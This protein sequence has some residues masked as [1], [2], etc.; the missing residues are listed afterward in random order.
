MKKGMIILMFQSGGQLPCCSQSNVCKVRILPLLNEQV[1]CTECVDVLHELEV[2][3]GVLR[4]CVYVW[5]T[6]H[7][8]CNCCDGLMRC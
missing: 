8:N 7:L 2:S 1:S 6:I 5:N 4:W 3:G